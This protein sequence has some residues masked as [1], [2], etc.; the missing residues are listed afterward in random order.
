LG[1]RDVPF[2]SFVLTPGASSEH[3]RSPGGQYSP[4]RSH[5]PDHP[6]GLSL[7]AFSVSPRTLCL[8]P[9]KRRDRLTSLRFVVLSCFRTLLLKRYFFLFPSGSRRSLSDEVITFRP[10]LAIS[11]PFLPLPYPPLPRVV[12]LLP[13]EPDLICL[14]AQ[15]CTS[16]TL[17]RLA[18]FR[19]RLISTDLS[20]LA[21]ALFLSPQDPEI[22]EFRPQGDRVVPLPPTFSSWDYSSR[23]VNIL[24]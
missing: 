23:V 18:P 2:V 24:R 19:L 3:T 20:L 7:Q 6:P 5:Y 11:F 9:K 15:V 12:I 21:K 22:L 16:R 10:G 1:P 8:P 14:R 13:G 17:L 4:L